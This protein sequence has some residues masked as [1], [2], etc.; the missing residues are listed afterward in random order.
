MIQEI[1]KNVVSGKTEHIEELIRNTKGFKLPYKNPQ[2]YGN[3]CQDDI[4][5]V[6]DFL[7]VKEI[8]EAI[9]IFR[10]IEST[11]HPIG[12]NP[13]LEE[14]P[15][16]K[17]FVESNIDTKLYEAIL[18]AIEDKHRN[19]ILHIGNKGSGKTISQN[20]LLY[21]K[22][23]EFERNKIFWIRCDC[24]KLYNLWRVQSSLHKL[25]YA[26]SIQEYLDIQMVYVL[27]KYYK[28]S[29][30]LK[31]IFLGLK[32]EE[33][34]FDY[35]M[36]HDVD[37]DSKQYK[38]NVFAYKFIEKLESEIESHENN[39]PQTNF[40]Y[41]VDKIMVGSFKSTKQRAKRRW[42]DLSLCIQTFMQKKGYKILFIADGIDNVNLSIPSSKPMYIEMKSQFADF[43]R[44]R[45]KNLSQIHLASLR[46]RTLNEM[47]NLITESSDTFHYSN[48]KNLIFFRQEKYDFTFLS[49][50]LLSRYQ[51]VI[52]EVLN[53]NLKYTKIIDKITRYVLNKDILDKSTDDLY[54]ENCRNYLIEL[55]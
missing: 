47:Q 22:N 23:K 21:R 5:H 17:F 25:A 24:H 19:S 44:K 35:L 12:M 10:E 39:N 20:I 11:F 27:C 26:V 13:H 50:I 7:R 29:N 30:L 51:Y 9:D 15:P 49:E 8:K 46:T 55:F 34:K 2:I 37:S 42:I 54:H 18:N 28:K 38:K 45:P 14:Y 53:P 43:V 52:N 48:P 1:I 36:T 16:D 4:Y 31:E 32:N 33:I 6:D 41:A 40:S 3:L